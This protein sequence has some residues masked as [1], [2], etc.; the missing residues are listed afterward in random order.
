[1]PPKKVTRRANDAQ[2]ERL[3]H[4]LKTDLSY[5]Q[6]LARRIAERDN[7]KYDSAMRRLQR[8]I[9]EAGEKRSFARAP[10][11]KRRE[12][13]QDYREY[14]RRER[15]VEK[16][17]RE[18]ARIFEREARREEEE[19]EEEGEFDSYE[20]QLNDLR[21]IT[22]YHDGNVE[23]TADKLS[24]SAR[25]ERLLDL[26][27]TG[28][29]LDVLTMRGGGEL[30]DRVRDFFNDLDSA[31]AQEIQDFSD[32]LYNLPDWQIGMILED[33][34]SGATTFAEWLD[35]WYDDDMDMDAQDSEY[36]RVW[37]AAYKRAKA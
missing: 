8:Y 10:V 28:E 30:A 4:A 12:V 18:E 35:A 1:M 17:A 34:S 33:I 31:T 16:R 5:R 20:V 6:D 22:A 11:E 26:A 29:G 24:L 19:E 23:E 32:L 13:R 2:V 7:I 15:E 9:T 14:E 25:G 21:A 27:V 37:R 36:W 3:L